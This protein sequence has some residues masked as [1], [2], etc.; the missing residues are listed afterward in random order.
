[1]GRVGLLARWRPVGPPVP[2]GDGERVPIGIITDR[3]ITM[4]LDRVVTW[5]HMKVAEVMTVELVTAA[6]ESIAFNLPREL[7]DAP[8]EPAS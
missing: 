2:D 7:R 3:D 6:E 8:P 4:A 5:P 1:M